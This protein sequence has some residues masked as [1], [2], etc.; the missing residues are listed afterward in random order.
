M[1]TTQLTRVGLDNQGGRN[2][3]TGKKGC[4]TGSEN[5]RVAAGN[6]EF[7]V[8][9]RNRLQMQAMARVG[10]SITRQTDA[11]RSETA[12]GVKALLLC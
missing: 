5:R 1:M 4:G 8:Q 11:G 7:G 10:T 12:L 9:K 6:P 3:A 2:D